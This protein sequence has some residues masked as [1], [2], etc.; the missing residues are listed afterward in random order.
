V[1]L[2]VLTELRKRAVFADLGGKALSG[3]EY[4]TDGG[5]TADGSAGG[6]I[7]R[8]LDAVPPL[9]RVLAEPAGPAPPAGR[10]ARLTAET[11]DDLLPPPLTRAT[12]S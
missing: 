9:A 7:Y 6:G 8:V 2:R 5:C 11:K 1:A 12:S 3:I 4:L 10:Y